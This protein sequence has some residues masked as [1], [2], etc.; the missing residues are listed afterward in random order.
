MDNPR[1]SG[2]SHIFFP[3]HGGGYVL[4]DPAG[5]RVFTCEFAHLARCRVVSTDYRLA[6]ENP[7]PAA[8]E[9]TVTAY[10]ALLGQGVRSQDIRLFHAVLPTGAQA[11]D[12]LAKFVM[13]QWK[14]G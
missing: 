3:L 1:S 7:F 4:G 11:V 2:P 9:D 12:T 13:E 5:S 10:F 8:L 6:P 14:M